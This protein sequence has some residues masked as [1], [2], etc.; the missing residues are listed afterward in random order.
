MM[1]K[2]TKHFLP[3]M[4]LLLI[5]VMILAACNKT[6]IE[7]DEI[8]DIAIPTKDISP[9]EVSIVFTG[10]GETGL[11]RNHLNISAMKNALNDVLMNDLNITVDFNWVKYESY[12]EDIAA[13]LSSDDIHDM[14]QTY[15]GSRELTAWVDAGFV[16]DIFDLRNSYMLNLCDNIEEINSDYFE[17]TREIYGG[18]YVMPS[19]GYY[20][21]R[22]IIIVPQYLQD[23]Y[24]KEIDSVE[25]YEDYLSF[26]KINHDEL[27]P[28]Y[29]SALTIIENYIIGKGYMRTSSYEYLSLNSDD[30]LILL[31]ERMDEFIEV[32]EMIQ[33]WN[34]EGYFGNSQATRS[35]SCVFEGKTASALLSYRNIETDM[36]NMSKGN[37][38][39]FHV[40]NKDTRIVRAAKGE[41]F[42]FAANSDNAA[43]GMR[44]LEWVHESQNNYDIIEYGVQNEH[45]CLE[46]EKLYIQDTN[47]DII[48]WWGSDCFDDY[49]FNRPFVSEPENYKEI[50]SAITVDNSL[51]LDDYYKKFGIDI[52]SLSEKFEDDVI[53]DIREKRSGIFEKR[54]DVLRKYHRLWNNGD[55]S[56]SAEDIINDLYEADG[57][58]YYQLTEEINKIYKDSD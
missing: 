4:L 14:I 24:N 52:D 51:D 29:A 2:K 12:A 32:Y 16:M 38:Y 37:Q 11:P 23:E 13:M 42:C 5:V 54:A 39:Y 33:R 46:N 44:F 53:Q 9:K 17:V 6:Q 41:G 48:K 43:E 15:A 20:P 26:I 58:L 28:G 25:E 21:I 19:L 50:I 34:D 45:Y 10:Y 55:F 47:K 57:D 36:K 8:N 1:S 22:D 30:Y 7:L 49:R 3:F 31:I 27:I 40:L 56:M 18:V 35:Y